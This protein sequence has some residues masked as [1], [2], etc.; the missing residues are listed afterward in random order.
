ML[1][2][3]YKYNHQTGYGDVVGSFRPRPDQKTPVKIA[4]LKNVRLN[5]S[6]SYNV[7]QTSNGTL[8]ISMVAPNGAPSQ[9]KG[10][11]DRKWASR[12]LY[13]KAGV[14]TLDNQGNESEAGAAT[15]S[16]LATTHR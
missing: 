14:Y 9:W 6:F 8:S 11:L 13:F 10:T 5:Q 1:M 15:F 4:L 7:N 2:L 16:Q 12:D 3:D